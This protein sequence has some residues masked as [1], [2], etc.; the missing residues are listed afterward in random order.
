MI[1]ADAGNL[2]GGLFRV[3]DF[4]KRFLFFG[5]KG[6]TGKTS[7]AA[8]AA[9]ALARKGKR[10][11]VVST[12]PAHSL[13]D[14]FARSI[15][16]S[17][18]CLE[19]NLWALEVDPEKEARAYME[20]IKE[21]LLHVVSPVIVEDIQR[22]IEI[23]Y[24]SPG[25]E[26]AAVFD[27]F[28]ELMED[29]GHVY[30]VLIFDTAPTGHTLRLLSLPEMLGAWI[31]H[32]VEKRRK[33]M[34]LMSMA[35]KYEKRLR[36]KVESDPVIEVLQRRQN[37]FAFAR[38]ILTDSEQTVFYFV[39]NPEKLPL[40]ETERAV[41]I[42]EKYGIPVGKVIVN[43][44]VPEGCGDFWESRRKVQAQW[45]QEIQ[46]RFSSRGVLTIPLLETDVTGMEQL[47]L[48][49]RKLLPGAFESSR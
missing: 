1:F 28:V 18:V 12:D 15:G 5:G 13:G 49:A 29:V 24:A 33:A 14:A 3:D 27:K 45:L 6:G 39:L 21:K 25:A 22:Q 19:Q 35:A 2:Y 48:I 16:N 44:V 46:S 4:T 34:E 20:G 36:E 38:E 23:A 17:V 31:E 40:Y 42:L 10:V 9:L 11:L 43:R 30:D 32:L 41:N 26:E 8:A 7:C 37:K 47:E